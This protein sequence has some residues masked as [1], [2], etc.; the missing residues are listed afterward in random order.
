MAESDFDANADLYE[1]DAPSQVV[2]LKELQNAEGDDRWFGKCKTE[3]Q[4]AKRVVNKR[5]FSE[6]TTEASRG[7]LVLH[8]R[9]LAAA[10]RSCKRYCQS[11]P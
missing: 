8:W 1:Y 5:E 7:D 10:L 6:T 3:H 11:K 9:H 4:N 2:D